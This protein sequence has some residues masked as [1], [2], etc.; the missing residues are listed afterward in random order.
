MN[1]G[2]P[3]AGFS[4][5]QQKYEATY[6]FPFQL[7]GMMGPSCAVADVRGDKVT[8]WTGTQGPFRT[9]DAVA[10]MLEIPRK[11]FTSC[12]GKVREATAGWKAMMWPKT[13][14]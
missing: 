11:M 12:T 10:K 2:N 8:I 9:R 14:R 5:A 3:D 13:R 4:Q 6:R 7:H 1:R